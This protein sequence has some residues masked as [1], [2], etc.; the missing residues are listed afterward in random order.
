MAYTTI[1]KSTDYFNTKL[2]TGNGVAGTNITGVGFQP[3][4]VWIKRR[5]AAEFHILNDSVRGVPNNIYS[6]SNQAQDSG[7]LMS[8]IISDG[9]TVQTD[10]S[11]NSN[12]HT[13]A[14]WNWKAATYG[15]TYYSK[16]EGGTQSNSDTASAIG[17][18][19]GS[20]GS[21][22]W[23][24]AVNRDSGF[25]IVKY[26]GT[27]SN[28][29][30]GHGLGSAPSM[31]MVKQ[32]SSPAEAWHVYHKSTGN[33]GSLFLNSTNAYNA[34]AN[35]WNSTSPTS[36]VFSVGTQSAI[37]GSGKNYVAYCFAEKTGYSKFG[38]YTGNG[39]ADGTFVFTGMKPAFIMYKKSNASG[40]WTMEDNKRDP[41]NVATHGLSADSSDSENT[42]SGYWDVDLLSNGFKFKTSE[43][44]TNGSGQSYIYMAFAEAPLVG[45]NNVPCTA[46]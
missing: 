31:I 14:S 2:Y 1:N 44:E 29:T 17:I 32:L 13:Y 39:N 38:S 21:N 18:T 24:V 25:S 19:A 10:G 34:Q 30:V 15:A 46:R 33:G 11:V 5:S 16:V 42:G 6:N 20:N 43:Q 8:A 7:N 35:N 27:G 36:T 22:T 28:A 41:F 23:R 37:N 12:T 26:V 45:S 40:R 9:F 3:D 4:L